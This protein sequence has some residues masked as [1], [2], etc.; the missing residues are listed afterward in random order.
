MIN[1]ITS[2]HAQILSKVKTFCVYCPNERKDTRLPHAPKS[3]G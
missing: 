2:Y 3:F 1:N